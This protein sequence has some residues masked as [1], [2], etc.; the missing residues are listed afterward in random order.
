[1]RNGDQPVA[2]ATVTISGEV[3]DVAETD[4]EG[5]FRIGALVDGEY[6]LSVR[7]AGMAFVPETA[8]ITIDG[9]DMGVRFDVAPSGGVSRRSASEVFREEGLAIRDG[10]A[11]ETAIVV[12]ETEPADAVH[13]FVEIRHPM[14]NDLSLIVVAPDGEEVILSWADGGP[15][16]LVGWFGR[17][18]QATG[19]IW[20]LAGRPTGTWRLRVRDI[21][22]GDEGTLV[23]WGLAFVRDR[24]GQNARLVLGCGASGQGWVQAL[25][26]DLRRATWTRHLQ[27]GYTLG[28][29]RPSC[30]DVD[31]DGLEEMAIGV[32]RG[33]AG[34]V[35]LRDDETHGRALLA[36]LRVPDE[37]YCAANGE[38]R[39]SLGDIDGDGRAEIVVGL[40]AGGGGRVPWQAYNT[41]NGEA[42]P[43]CGDVEFD[44]RDE[45]VLGLGTNPGRG[46]W[47][48]VL[49]DAAAGL[50]P[51]RWLAIPW[52]AYR[53]AGGAV[54]PALGDLDGDRRDEVA[55]GTG[56]FPRS[57]GCVAILDDANHAF[58]PRGWARLRWPAYNAANG[59]TWP[60]FTR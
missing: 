56:P 16:D 14:R 10:E 33:G 42:W 59:E 30:G 25:D 28:E 6:Q 49:D 51:M 7:R 2:G 3:S 1:V 15:P 23:R 17:E 45:V 48:V 26:A 8:C 50:R 5:G 19:P 46:G 22:P 21:A 12:E 39:P 38:T 57:G 53:A 29:T 31:G 27:D 11:L 36:W 34:W 9:G 4:G 47:A 54:R 40:G 32:G 24:S 18:L 55:L 20:R 35:A 43:A 13:V 60:A 41:R 58:A 52:P 37:A 44:G